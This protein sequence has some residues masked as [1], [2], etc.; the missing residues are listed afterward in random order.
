MKNYKFIFLLLVI[1]SFMTAC[2]EDLLDQKPIDNLSIA[3]YYNSQS[4]FQEAV[5]GIYDAFQTFADRNYLRFSELRSDNANGAKQADLEDISNDSPSLN[6]GITNEL[7]QNL[8]RIVYL[9]NTIL[10]RIDDV[11]FKDPEIKNQSKGEAVFFRGLGHYYI[12]KFFG[13]GIVLT[14]T[15]NLGNAKNVGSLHDQ[16]AFFSQAENDFGKAIGLLPAT[17]EYGRV[18]RYVAESFLA[19]CY[20]FTGQ[21]SKA[22]P[23][24]ESVLKNAGASFEP[25]YA[26][27]HKEDHNQEVIFAATF[28]DGDD[29]ANTYPQVFVTVNGQLVDGYISFT[30]DLLNHFEDN[31]LRKTATL[32]TGEWTS[33]VSGKTFTAAENEFRNIKLENGNNGKNQGTGDLI[34][35]RYTDMLLY[36]AETLGSSTGMNNW[37]ALGIVNRVRE[38]AGLNALPGVTKNDILKERR[39]ELVME[40]QRWWDQVRTDNTKGIGKTYEVPEIEMSRMGL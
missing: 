11:E 24:L 29:I 39:S 4:D 17:A 1:T 19:D 10:E 7:W 16:D 28:A 33:P 25:V 5:V 2:E 31:D 23:L 18:T 15:I 14:A 27:I 9:S 3:N 32:E 8:Y 35:L 22:K 37:T 12:G 38:R 6:T 26:N 20:M 40:G 36:Y 34:F 13:Q 21:L 30:N